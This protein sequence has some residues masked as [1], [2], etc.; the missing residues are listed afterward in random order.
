M[1]VLKGITGH[2]GF[3]GKNEGRA[4]NG[5]GDSVLCYVVQAQFAKLNMEMTEHLSVSS[6]LT[7]YTRK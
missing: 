7:T 1:L 4:E 6:E 3:R 5:D 2:N